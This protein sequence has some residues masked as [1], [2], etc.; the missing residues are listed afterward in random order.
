MA[1]LVT[2]AVP[3]L[4]AGAAITGNELVP[5]HQ[6]GRLVRMRQVDLS[7]AGA[8]LRTAGAT[9]PDWTVVVA[10]NGKVYPADP[11]VVAHCGLVLGLV[12]AGVPSGTTARVQFSG[13]LAGTPSSY[14]SGVPLFISDGTGG[15]PLGGL[16]V[17]A[18]SAVGYWSQRVATSGSGSTAVLDLGLAGI[19]DDGLPLVLASNP[20]TAT[21]TA[22]GLMSAADKV[23]VDGLQVALDARAP[24]LATLV[25]NGTVD[26]RTALSV[27]DALQGFGEWLLKPG[28]IRISS[29]ITLSAHYRFPRGV[30]LKPDNGVTITFNGG[31]TAGAYQIFDLSAGGSVAGLKIAQI[32]WFHSLQGVQSDCQPFCQ[33]AFDAVVDGAPVYWGVGPYYWGTGRLELARGQQSRGVGGRGTKIRWLTS[34]TNFI[35]VPSGNYYGHVIDGFDCGVAN[36]ALRPTSGICFHLEQGSVHLSD[37]TIQSAAIGVYLKGSSTGFM[38]NFVI[39]ECLTAGIFNEGTNDVFASDFIISSLWDTVTVSNLSGN[40]QVGEQLVVSGTPYKGVYLTPLGGNK[41]RLRLP[42]TTVTTSTTITGVSSGA[43][44][45]FVAINYDFGLG[46]IRLFGGNVESFSMVNGDVIGGRYP[47]STDGTAFAR[48]SCPAFNKA[49]NVYFDTS[50]DGLQLTNTGKF[51][52]T[53]C[54]STGH[55]GN[56]VDLGSTDGVQWAFSQI[57]GNLAW[58][59]NASAGNKHFD[60]AFCDLSLNQVGGITIGTGVRTNLKFRIVFCNFDVDFTQPNNFSAYAVNLNENSCDYYTVAGNIWTSIAITKFK[61]DSTATNKNINSPANM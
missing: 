29:N 32:D 5:V 2:I 19:I 15:V 51:V 16:T 12:I 59:V 47:L 61:D 31:I 28:T 6:N 3:A 22:N 55:S 58:G 38:N 21:P 36:Y 41:H 39:Q 60:F 53:N 24:I 35:H 8:V 17:T 52:F 37:F 20:N 11:R 44:A 23:K 25:A 48:G 54:W 33:K 46:C 42:I 13:D 40:F 50:H 7:A 4:P 10:I 34:T 49:T 26:D 1:D 45:T 27:A 14:A 9:I 30:M 43:S 18:P 57:T 56:G